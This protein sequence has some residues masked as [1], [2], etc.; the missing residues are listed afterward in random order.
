MCYSNNTKMTK[1]INFIA[2]KIDLTETTITASFINNKNEEEFIHLNP[3]DNTN[4]FP[5]NITFNNNEIS[6]CQQETNENTI[7]NFVQDLFNNPTELKRYQFTYQNKEYEVLAETLLAMIIN[8]F[9]KKV[10]KKGIVNRFLFKITNTEQEI[11]N[12]IKST[13]VNINIPN[14]FTEVKHKHRKREEYYIDEEYVMFD[15]LNKN[16]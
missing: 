4:N 13:L 5:I 1:E 8:E 15:I 6:Y 3:N 2:F 16:E 10:D 7:S 9:K 14:S 11:I 12:R